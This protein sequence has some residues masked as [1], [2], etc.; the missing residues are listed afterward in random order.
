M[1]ERQRSSISGGDDWHS[2]AHCLLRN[3][4]PPPRVGS[5][6]AVA[7]VSPRKR[8]YEVV[9]VGEIGLWD[10]L[11]EDE[12]VRKQCSLGGREGLEDELVDLVGDGF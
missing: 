8:P 12:V 7:Y 6:T 5:T 1:N 3:T 4:T 10:V 11:C 9:Y 2:A